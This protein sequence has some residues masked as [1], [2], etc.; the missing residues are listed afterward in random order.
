MAIVQISK[1]Q[2]RSGNLVDLPQLDDA[3][4]GWAN[5]ARRLFIG[6]T[7]PN[8]NV[9]VLT[10]YSAISFSQIDGAV[11]NLNISNLTAANGQVLSF[12]G[13]DWVNRGGNAG[14]LLTLGDVGNV[15][16][17]GGAIGYVL[18]TDG[19]GNL[20]WTPKGTLVA[21]ILN[22]S[23][24][25]PA[26]VTTVNDNFFANGA[27]ITILDPQG[28]TELAGGIYFAN[29]LTTTT[30]A[31]Y[32]DS[33]LSTGENSTSYNAYSYT[34]VSATTV[35]TNVITVA[36]SSPFTVGAAVKFIGDM[37]TS[38]ISNI[39]TYYVQAK[40]NSTSLK[41]ATSADA[42]AANVVPLQTTS[43]LT[44][45]VY[46]SD[47]QAVSTLGSSV[48]FSPAGG[49][50]TTVQFNS[51]GSLDGSAA[52][53]FN[54][55]SGLLTLTGN[56]NVGNLNATG[57]ST[58][59]RFISNIANGTPPLQVTSITQVANLN[60][61]TSG[62]VANGNSNVNIP[63]AN[64]NVNISAVGNANILVV[65]G[66]GANIAGTLN[67]TGNANVGNI[68]ATTAIITTG[69][70]TTINGGLLQNG[71]SNIAIT[72]NGNISITAAGGTPELVITSTGAN[73]TG[74][75]DVSGNANVGNL[76][77]G[78]LIVATGNVTGG[79][80]TTAGALSVTGNANVGNIGAVNGV[81]TGNITAGNII[82]TVVGGSNPVTTTGNITGGNII[83]TIAAGANTIS[84]TG[85][86]IAG[87]LYANSGTLGVATL[88]VSGVSNLN[89]VGNVRIFGGS[90][91]Q[92]L[93]T[94]GA[95]NLSWTDPN[96]GYYLHTQVSASSTWT[97]T[98]NLNRQYVTVEPID[99]SG[100]SYTGRYDYPTISYTNA[101]AF[102]MTFISAVAGYAAVTGG[103]TNINSVSVGN[104]TPGG[105]NTQ[106][107]F[108]DAGALAGSSGLVYNKTTGTLTATLYVGS[109]A[110]LTNIAGANVTGAV[111]FAT[112]ANA[113][114]GA[115]V[116]GTV[117]FATTAN[118]VAGANVTGAVAFATTAN[119]VAG[120]NVTGTVANATF[121]TSAGTAGTVTTAAQPNITSVGTL[122]SLSVSGALTSTQLTAGANTTAGNITGNWTLTAGSRL[123]ATYA[124]LAEYYEAD[125]RYLP[126]TVLM[127]GG[128]KEVTLAEDGTSKVAGVVSTNPAYVM[129]STCPGLLTAVALQ[130]RVPCKVR[131]KIS[132]GDMLIS[133]GN[134][135]ARPNQFPAMG[136]VI[137]KALQDFDGYEGVIEVAVGRL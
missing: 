6:K 73:I 87:N 120:A 43:G 99:S 31:L 8:E 74:T 135:F 131:G 10:S 7:T 72:A 70:I 103:G 134:G 42:N 21:S 92:I 48:T 26:V 127:F 98:H 105:V 36:N 58:A 96:G 15:K 57:V 55:G 114:A 123:T 44:A 47:G 89:A 128:D 59:T 24:A 63:A 136:T 122:T 81:F 109:G 76:G 91:N 56:A 83:G 41:I 80:L 117:A 77:T 5:D 115:N 12:D 34:T 67:A 126:G 2:Q 51:N 46:Q 13:S 94:D 93:K 61:A 65:T 107:Q 132:K 14:G 86:V 137:G 130:G 20:S 64:G 52:F 22:I 108:N 60:V 4:L 40:P 16:I 133:G 29:T 38:N 54:S 113:V 30:F 82:G 119:A 18:Q 53:V 3:E 121:A 90:A 49:T 35:S 50:N 95:G 19:T 79:N 129:N 1:I 118:A 68:G 28:M 125:E 85:N 39:A 66:T 75:L 84:T 9:E 101:N 102:T 116:T 97:V 112:T 25:N 111:A 17:D 78:G 69:N 106:V 33:G 104:S 32:T 124:D 62:S 27:Q 37:S 23:K 110:N 100:N 71:N 88:N 45:E 11:G